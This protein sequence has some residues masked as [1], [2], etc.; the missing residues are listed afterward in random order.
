MP[1]TIPTHTDVS[2]ALCPHQACC[3]LAGVQIP[4]PAGFVLLAFGPLKSADEKLAGAVSLRDECNSAHRFLTSMNAEFLTEQGYRK[5]RPSVK[6]KLDKA[7]G[8]APLE[9]RKL[10]EEQKR[11]RDAQAAI[12]DELMKRSILLQREQLKF[13]RQL[14]AAS[15]EVQKLEEQVAEAGHSEEMMAD[16]LATK[17]SEKK[18]TQ[19]QLDSLRATQAKMVEEHRQ[20]IAETNYNTGLLTSA[21]YSLN[22]MTDTVVLDATTL[23]TL[24]T[25]E[26]HISSLLLSMLW[27]ICTA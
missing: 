15:E 11:I 7:V 20:E 24:R 27:C 14:Q 19:A 3:W 26:Y 25:V 9:W 18:E 8:A 1:H 13:E 23:K 21:Q 2:L 17:L 12:N 22:A 5:L 6:E 16:A 4:S 10:G